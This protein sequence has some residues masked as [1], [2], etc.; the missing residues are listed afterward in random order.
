MRA[1]GSIADARV[2]LSI[3][4]PRPVRHTGMEQR[5]RGAAATAEAVAAASEAIGDDIDPVSDAHASA[6]YRRQMARVMAR[7]AVLAAI[8]SAAT[9]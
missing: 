9:R 2:V 5:L 8:E 1:N 6:G 3:V 7:R 4:G